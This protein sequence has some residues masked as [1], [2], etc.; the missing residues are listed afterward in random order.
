M[1]RLRPV[2]LAAVL[3]LLGACAAEA[4]EP[5]EL[6]LPPPPPPSRVQAQRPG[7]APALRPGTAEQPPGGHGAGNGTEHDTLAEHPAGGAATV[8]VSLPWRVVRDGVTGCA[9]PAPLRLAREGRDVLPRLLAE[10]RA[11]GGCRTTFRV[12]EWTL[13][14]SDADLV[15]LRL[16][17]G[18]PLTLW[19]MRSDVIA[20]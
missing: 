10:A 17:N 12:N 6:P 19:F 4:P 14:G 2:R 1:M 8:P 16:V 20:P 9:E 5:E 15:R 3:L 7:G 11:A 13:E 18:P